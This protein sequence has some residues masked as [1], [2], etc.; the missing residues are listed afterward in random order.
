MLIVLFSCSEENDTTTY[1]F[2]DA[3]IEGYDYSKCACCGGWIINLSDSLQYRTGEIE[4]LEEGSY[5]NP[6]EVKIDWKLDY[7]CEPN[8]FITINKLEFK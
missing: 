1:S 7:I 3:T 6:I 5:E 8:R 2:Q 4:E